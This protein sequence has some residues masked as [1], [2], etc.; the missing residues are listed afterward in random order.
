MAE[1][2]GG[3][4]AG[5]ADIA[6]CAE[7]TTRAGAAWAGTG[8]TL[9]ICPSTVGSP[10]A[11]TEFTPVSSG[12]DG[13]VSDPGAVLAE[14]ADPST[15]RGAPRCADSAGA[16]ASIE[17][18][19]SAEASTGGAAHSRRSRRRSL[20]LWSGRCSSTVRSTAPE[21]SFGGPIQ[22]SANSDAGTRQALAPKAEPVDKVIPG[23]RP[24]TMT[25]ASLVTP[26]K[27]VPSGKGSPEIPR[28]S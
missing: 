9:G 7:T 17:I 16:A 2:A 5:G 24:L 10:A 12:A 19:G 23:I 25:T 13:I 11:G 22:A 8:G 3:A 6:G 26:S 20:M 15:R 21:K 28:T 14:F 1:G 4:A 27:D 18:V